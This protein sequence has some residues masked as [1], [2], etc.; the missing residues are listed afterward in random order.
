MANHQVMTIVRTSINQVANVASQKVYEAN[1]DIT[2]KYEY[3]STLDSRTSAIC[4][5][6]D[7][8]VFEYGKGPTPPQHF[9]CRSTT[10]PFIDKSW[11]EKRG[12]EPPTE[13]KRAAKWGKGQTGRQVPAG[14]K[15]A[16][17]LRQ[18]PIS[19]QEEV[20]GK[21]KSQYFSK[22]SKKEGAQS[23]LRKIIRKDG[24]EKTL[25]QLQASYG[26]LPSLKKTTVEVPEV[27]KKTVA[28]PEKAFSKAGSVTIGKGAY[29]EAKLVSSRAGGVVVKKGRISEMEP[30]ILKKLKGSGVAPAY[31]GFKSIA[32]QASI[33]T[34]SKVNIKTGYL[35]M[36]KARGKPVLKQLFSKDMTRGDARG[37]MDSYLVSRKAIH[38]KGIAH[39]DMH[40]LNFFYDKKTKKGMLIDF[41]LAKN[42]PKAA[43][44]EALGTGKA[45]N[46]VGKLGGDWQSY[47]FIQELSIVGPTGFL[48]EK[49][50]S[51]RKFISNRTKVRRLLKKELDGPELIARN[52]RDRTDNLPG[53]SEA[54]A[55]K[56][57]E[58]LYEGI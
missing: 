32:R 14:M 5:S 44:I 35:T 46:M 57:I 34:T 18:Q 37:I 52:I 49:G 56:F 33:S 31:Y 6:L 15:Y 54:K 48:K 47:N 11:Y 9:N 53:I 42:D 26:K 17:W 43:L 20:L 8:K 30:N 10:V 27:I 40:G 29:G 24:S 12:F 50:S 55:L 58:M 25:K 51:Y 45:N 38:L 13:G 22:L 1:Q 39:N 2:E 16:D 28:N 7:G 41:G 3:V 36:G 4:A 21:W 19:V 23:A